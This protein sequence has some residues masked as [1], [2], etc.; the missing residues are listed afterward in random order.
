[1]LSECLKQNLDFFS[2]PQ[3]VPLSLGCL[4]KLLARVIAPKPGY[5]HAYSI[6]LF[7]K[8]L[9]RSFVYEFSLWLTR[10]MW[11]DLCNPVW[12][13]PTAPA[14]FSFLLCLGHHA[15]LHL[16]I[17][18]QLFST[19]A[20]LTPVSPVHFPPLISL[21]PSDHFFSET[22]SNYSTRNQDHF[23]SS[24]LLSSLPGMRSQ[25]LT[26]CRCLSHLPVGRMLA[27][28]ELG[29]CLVPCCF[30]SN[31]R[32]AGLTVNLL[33]ELILQYEVPVPEG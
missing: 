5:L 9:I 28:W 17:P 31:Q 6:L 16:S 11:K 29:L 4:V 30:L 12:R 21:S 18:H 27:P 25:H 7:N 8:F 32:D 14:S 23:R 13:D 19:P 10:P 33:S 3:L 22:F 15:C 26:V 2:H 24:F 20:M 1:M